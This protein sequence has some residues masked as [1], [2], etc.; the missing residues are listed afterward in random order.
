MMV[1]LHL[2]SRCCGQ[3]KF[4]G[5]FSVKVLSPLETSRVEGVTQSIEYEDPS[6]QV[7]CMQAMTDRVGLE[8]LD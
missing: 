5:R 4:D 3:E 2:I 7:S 8:A 6:R 1:Y